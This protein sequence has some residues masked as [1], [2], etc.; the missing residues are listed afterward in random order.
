MFAGESCTKKYKTKKGILRYIK[1]K[2]KTQ[3]YV[4]L[5]MQELSKQIDR[6]VS[7]LSNDDCFPLPTKS[8]FEVFNVNSE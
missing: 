4:L 1:Q 6:L 3:P 5:T 2:H 8:C 7:K